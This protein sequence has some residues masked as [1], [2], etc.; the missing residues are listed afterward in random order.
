MTRSVL[1]HHLPPPPS[2]PPF[3]ALSADVNGDGTADAIL[4]ENSTGDWY[5]ALS[6]GSSFGSYTRWVDD[7]GK[8][9]GGTYPATH[10]A[11][12]VNGD[13]K[14]DAIAVL[15][16]SGDWHVALSNGSSFVKS[17]RWVA[18][19][20]HTYGGSQ[21]ATHLAADADGDGKADAIAALHPSGDWYA[22]TSTGLAFGSYTRWIADFG[23]AP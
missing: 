23:A 14:A 1:H 16:D 21:P 10:L 11:A 13:G 20:G 4:V 9:Y 7:W 22:S 15:H 6:N 3:D 17:G 5:V 19:L 8:T 12:D 18:D 2:P